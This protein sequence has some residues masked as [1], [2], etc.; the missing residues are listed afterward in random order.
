MVAC[1]MLGSKYVEDWAPGV[2]L[3]A[4]WTGTSRDLLAANE[5][6]LLKAL[7]FSLGVDQSEFM[8]LADEI[9]GKVDSPH[10]QN[11]SVHV[12]LDL[13]QTAIRAHASTLSLIRA[14][15]TERYQFAPIR[16][17]LPENIPHLT[18]DML[19]QRC[20]LSGGNAT[21]GSPDRGSSLT[22]KVERFSPY[23]VPPRPPVHSHHHMPPYAV[24]RRVSVQCRGDC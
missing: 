14:L 10:P 11:E 2:G 12:Y 15:S 18:L 3:W 20:E 8:V 19:L 16:P 22:V 17:S 23:F 4:G 24:T 6:V 13:I 7:T 21:G 5:I 1:M 9:F